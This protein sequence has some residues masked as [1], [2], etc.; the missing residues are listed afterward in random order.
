MEYFINF[1]CALVAAG[2]LLT[3]VKIF[4]IKYKSTVIISITILCL[5]FFSI[6]CV[7][8]CNSPCSFDCNLID[9]LKLSVVLKKEEQEIT[10][11]KLESELNKIENPDSIFK[12][13]EKIRVIKYEKIA[14]YEI[15][16]LSLEELS[17]NC[18][19]CRNS[20]LKYDSLLIKFNSTNEK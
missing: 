6:L 11:K 8:T 13:K 16:N 5:I 4:H 2:G 17:K 1:I 20:K 7:K 3:F 19:G 14:V 9:S 10:N 18:D 12:I 15:I